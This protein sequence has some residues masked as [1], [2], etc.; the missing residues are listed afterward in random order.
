ML[1]KL[2]VLILTFFIFGIP[3][4]LAEEAL[5]ADFQD[6]LALVTTAVGE[7]ILTTPAGNKRGLELHAVETLTGSTVSSAK[8][9][10]TFFSLS[11]GSALGIFE[12]S[13]VRFERYRQ[14]PF[15]PEKESHEYEP[16]RSEVVIRLKKGSLVFS[17]ERLSPLSSILIKLPAGQVEIH[18]A[19]GH[20]LC[21]DRGARITV[22]SGI[23]GY[24]YPGSDEQEF[25]NAPNTVRL[26]NPGG[27][28][29]RIVES[30]VRSNPS[31][32]LTQQLVGT[33]HHC[34]ERVIFKVNS[35]EPSIPHPILV[36]TPEA[37]LKPTPRPY[38]YSD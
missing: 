34:R 9:A 37:L 35:N 27:E 8:D 26:R 6:G 24:E 13:S 14:R 12:N 2:P 4:L 10:Y 21:D 31:H 30:T 20:V 33:S 7:V 5:T 16:S 29:T 36:R 3:L 23:V 25:I 18:K 22:T 17:G 15:P 11:N 32:V 38:H 1:A 28:L 19:S